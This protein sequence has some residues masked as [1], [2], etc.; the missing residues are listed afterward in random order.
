MKSIKALAAVALAS[1]LFIGCEEEEYFGID[2]SKPAPKE[3][4]YDEDNSSE[5]SI[6]VYWDDASMIEAGA[7]SAT[8]QLTTELNNGDNYD[9]SVTHT[10]VYSDE[11]VKVKNATT[12]TGLKK[13]S[14]YYVRIRANYARS[15]FSDWVY[16]TYNEEPSPFEIGVGFID[17]NSPVVENISYNES[18][19]SPTA[20]AFNYDDSKACSQN[21]T[22]IRFQLIN[23]TTDA[24][25]KEKEQTPGD[26]SIVIDGLKTGDQY[27][28]RARAEYDATSGT[29]CSEWVYAETTDTKVFEVGVGPVIPKDVAPTAKLHHATSSTLIFQWSESEFA[30]I[31]K[32]ARRPYNVQLY[33]DQACSKLVVSWEIPESSK[34]YGAFQPA[35]MFSGLMSDTKY[36][37]KVTDMQTN[38]TSDP[39]EGKT[40]AFNVVQISNTPA[41]VGD[42]ILSEDFSEF[43][44]GGDYIYKGPGYSSNGRSSATSLVPASGENPQ[45]SDLYLVGANTEMGLFNTLK[46]AVPSTRLATWGVINEGSAN[47]YMCVRPGHLKLGASKYICQIATPELSSLTGTATVEVSFKACPYYEKDQTADPLDIQVINVGSSTI[48]AQNVLTVNSSTSEELTLENK[49]EWT[50]YSVRVNN[51]TSKSRIAVGPVRKT[52]SAGSAQQRMY[53]DELVIKVISY[54][55]VMIQLDA[56]VVTAEALDKSITA[57]WEPVK[58]AASYVVEYKETSATE[59]TSHETGETSYKIADLTPETSY[60]IRVK[61]IAGESSSEYSKV[62]TVTTTAPVAEIK[63]KLVFANESQIGFQWSANNFENKLADI[64]DSYTIEVFKDEA[65]TNAVTKFNITGGKIAKSW[66]ATKQETMYNY[67]TSAWPVPYQTSFTLSGLD[68]DNN[69]VI[70]I[71]DSSKNI[72]GVLKATTSKSKIKEIPATTA[73]AGDIILYEDFSQF[74]Y[75]YETVYGTA[76]YSS[77]TRSSSTTMYKLEG[78]N[79]FAEATNAQLFGC[80]PGTHMGLFNTLKNYIPSTRMESWAQNVEKN[81]AGVVC[82]QPGSLKIGASS[83]TGTI[84]TPPLSCLSGNAKL[85]VSFDISPYMEAEPDPFT[86][87]VEVLTG[88]EVDASHFIKNATVSQ[89]KKFNIH[90]TREWKRVTI[91]LDNVEPG[92]RIGIGGSRDDGTNPGKAQHRLYLDNIQIKVLSY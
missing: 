81:K 10:I 24:V 31:A 6:S 1:S 89:E 42:V 34:I 71:T 76:G 4:T 5:T 84:V 83:L 40:S 53:L 66:D 46:G 68:P 88:G 26:G 73:S 69:Y 27:N 47:S 14:R 7:T 16:L 13:F 19:A 48:G 39:V 56:P 37:F 22:I 51:V 45:G 2:S 92:S 43:V 15:I 50:S 11:K 57:K 36:W 54:G 25:A 49:K 23:T 75:G 58:D 72:N 87:K 3:F 62:V 85:E 18:S 29:V 61:A 30:S 28:V 38:L 67:K 91:T 44:W 74:Y 20:L 64:D 90:E 65:M 35:F 32:D 63:T 55:S 21:A 17:K 8:V 9:N 70:R 86:A 12:F 41:S 80:K 78:E 52:G 77:C 59:W 60:D 82:V 33:S 79:P